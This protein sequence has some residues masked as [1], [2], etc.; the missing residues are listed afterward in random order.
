MGEEPG[1]DKDSRPT[2]SLG[3]A[4]HI[5]EY[6]GGPHPYYWIG[7]RDGREFFGSIDA[8]ELREL[9]SAPYKFLSFHNDDCGAVVSEKE[10]V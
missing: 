1:R 3:K 4:D 7:S 2:I 8:S 5:I 6:V 10:T 9:V